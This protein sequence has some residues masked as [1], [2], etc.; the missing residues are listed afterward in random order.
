MSITTVLGKKII[1]G[2]AKIGKDIVLGMILKEV[3]KLPYR[4]L[5][6]KAGQ[7]M[8]KKTDRY[9]YFTDPHYPIN[10]YRCNN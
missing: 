3:L 6:S 1:F 8:K 7:Y 5:L 2:V 10:K 9:V 4:K